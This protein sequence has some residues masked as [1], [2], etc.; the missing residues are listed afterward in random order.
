MLEQTVALTLNMIG[1]LFAPDRSVSND[2][3]SVAADDS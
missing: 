1:V 2:E 3:L